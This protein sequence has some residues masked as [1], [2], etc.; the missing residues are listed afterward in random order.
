MSCARP[1]SLDPRHASSFAFEA[2]PGE[3]VLAFT[4]GINECHYR[5]P[6]TSVSPQHLQSLL[7]EIGA[8]PE[9]YARRL[10]EMALAGVGGHP[11]GQD[12]IAL[13]VVRA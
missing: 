6:E 2:A 8:E 5:Y 3:L 7:A 13:V 11:G 10:V 12:N 1:R 4:D 9:R